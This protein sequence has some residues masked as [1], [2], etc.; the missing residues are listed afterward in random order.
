MKKKN[1]ITV[2]L[3]LCVVLSFFSSKV[4]ATSWAYPFVVWN[5]SVYV[6]SEETIDDVEK[7]IGKVTKY[8]DMEQ[9]GGNFSNVYPKGTKY[10]SIKGINT[11]VAIA[12][13]SSD[14]Q[15]IKAYLQGE[16]TYKKSF[17]EYIYNGLGVFAIL[18]IGLLIYSRISS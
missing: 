13:E 1:L 5:D 17:T 10:Y 15:Y 11:S 7:E 3:L 6:V 2:V 18:I 9:Y 16:Y 4:F 12:V 14:G 8:S